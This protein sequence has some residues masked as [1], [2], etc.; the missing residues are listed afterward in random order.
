[1]PWIA[2]RER[3]RERESVLGKVAETNIL[4]GDNFI[5]F[6]NEDLNLP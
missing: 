2:E 5:P 4:K 1:M 3:E 6:R